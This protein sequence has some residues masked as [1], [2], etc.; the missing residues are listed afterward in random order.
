MLT[1]F[2]DCPGVVHREFIPTG[3]TVNKEYYFSVLRRL[4]QAICRKRP[5]LWRENSWTLHDNVAAHNALVVLN[6]WPKTQK[7]TIQQAS[8]SLDIASCDF[9]LFLRLKFRLRCHHFNSIDARKQNL[10]ESR[11][12]FAKTA[13]KNVSKIG[14]NVGI[15]AVGGITLKENEI[16]FHE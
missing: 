8:Y 16:N 10:R 12:S 5:D 6:V 2:F 13:L 15:S 1:V 9:F 14:K 11:R 7:N 3:H 4:R